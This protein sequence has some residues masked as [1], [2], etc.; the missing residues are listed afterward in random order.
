MLL[1]VV[2]DHGGH[3]PVYGAAPLL[4]H[5]IQ[6]LAAV[7][8]FKI[9]TGAKKEAVDSADGKVVF[10]FLPIPGT[11]VG[12]TASVQGTYTVTA[13]AAKKYRGASP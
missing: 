4:R 12:Q 8:D 3:V 10:H 1:I 13:A 9:F 7:I 11:P 5:E 2:E 6:N